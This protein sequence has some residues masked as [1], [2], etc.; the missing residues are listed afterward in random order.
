LKAHYAD[1]RAKPGHVAVDW[2]AALADADAYPGVIFTPAPAPARAADDGPIAA[3]PA[4][5]AARRDHGGEIERLRA[6]IE[7]LEA[8]NE[9]LAKEN[10]RLT[11]YD[12][13]VERLSH[14]P[15]LDAGDVVTALVLERQ[16][17]EWQRRPSPTGE[18]RLY[19]ERTAERAGCARSTFSTRAARLQRTGA[20]TLRGETEPVR[21]PETRRPVM[22]PKTG[23]PEQRSETF[24]RPRGF[25]NDF[26]R[27]LL[28]REHAGTP[29]PD[30]E[31]RPKKKP[32][33]RYCPKHRDAVLIVETV[34]RWRC[35]VCEDVV[36]EK[37]RVRDPRTPKN[38]TRKFGAPHRP[39][40]WQRAFEG[41][42][43]FDTPPAGGALPKFDTPRDARPCQDSVS[44]SRSLLTESWHPTA[45]GRA[46]A[47]AFRADTAPPSPAPARA[48]PESEP[49]GEIEAPER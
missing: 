7:A 25:G 21:D 49:G 10:A 27:C 30:R 22:D 35:S 44:R 48:S 34:T 2:R 31:T 32:R 15:E 29:P 43:K 9:A 38:P 37:P 45:N 20:F 28:S 42:P 11:E 17:R 3:T 18:Y 39:E 19:M 12:G 1:L 26:L 16:T 46:G 13:L 23:T 47:D 36:D 41:V 5:G 40:G 14:D 33:G 8:Q 24:I 6:R 4:A